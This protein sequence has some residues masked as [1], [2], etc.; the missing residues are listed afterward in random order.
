MASVLETIVFEP[1]KFQQELQAFEELLKSKADLSESK[2]IQPFFKKSKYLTAYMGAFAPNIAVATEI[3]FEFEFFGDFRADI[4]L[5]SRHEKEFCVVEFEDGR[6][7]RIRSTERTPNGALDSSTVS[8]SSQIGSTTLKISR[9][10]KGS[11]PHSAP[12][13]SA[14]PAC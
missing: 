10:R 9:T 6:S 8:V 2:D 5:G 1:A 4:L 13:I 11:Q 12:A 14:L 7:S 3:C